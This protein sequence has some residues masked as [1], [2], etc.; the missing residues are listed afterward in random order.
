[1]PIENKLQ[2]SIIQWIGYG[3]TVAAV[4]YGIYQCI[5]H[6][7]ETPEIL[8]EEGNV[9]FLEKQHELALKKYK[10]ALSLVEEIEKEGK[11][12]KDTQI[13][14]KII[15]NI[16]QVYFAMKEYRLSRDFTEA[17]LAI[18]SLHYNSFKRLA[19]LEEIGH[20]FGKIKGLVVI[21]S[22]MILEKI[23][24][25]GTEKDSIKPSINTLN[26]PDTKENNENNENNVSSRQK[27]FTPTK[28]DR[29]LSNKIDYLS[30][31]KADK[32]SPRKTKD[33]YEVSF[34]KLD[35]V[36]SIFKESMQNEIFGDFIEYDEN[37]I[38][39]INSRNYTAIVEYLNKTSLTRYTKRALF[40]AGNI[41]YIQG[42]IPECLSL[43]D[44]S[45]CVYGDVLAIY[46]RSL[47]SITTEIDEKKIIEIMDK[48]DPIVKMYFAQI[49]LAK[50]NMGAYLANLLELE[51]E[52]SIS[53]PY[54][55]NIK[56]QYM[57]N[58]H[59]ESLSSLKKA[60]ELFPMDINMLCVGVEI[61]SQEISRLNTTE[62]INNEYI[63]KNPS[64]KGVYNLLLSIIA[65]LK[66]KEFSNSPRGVF[67]LYIGAS[68]LN[69]HKTADAMLKRAIELDPYN[70]TLLVQLAHLKIQSGDSFGFDL[71]EQAANISHEGAHEIYKTFYTLKSIYALQE[72]Y[73]EIA[74]L[75][76]SSS[77]NKQLTNEKEH[78]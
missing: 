11:K 10:E 20:G 15:N 47:N 29:L 28:W 14:A 48:K 57:L 27:E 18:D 12:P 2:N 22:Y 53:L 50:N 76:V 33:T 46:I 44:M 75:A 68:A 55:A 1:M 6:G 36:L 23:R 5:A 21:T 16:A 72:Y 73:P 69:R 64:S 42:H 8:K 4:L 65:K 51:E 32:I 25:E 77:E 59:N 34:V 60:L 26:E 70:R 66:T 17:V 38:Q 31:T 62:E 40:I 13:K 71:L 35:E 56:A 30:K 39:W 43:F 7:K 19:K 49:H 58:E 9:L 54:I 3:A 63:Q 52:G 37:I 24:S 74:I 78:N 45:S 41:K 61:L 67:F